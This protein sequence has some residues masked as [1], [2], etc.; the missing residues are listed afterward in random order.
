MNEPGWQVPSP[1]GRFRI[2]TALNE[3]LTWIYG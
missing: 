1:T 3:S 2:E